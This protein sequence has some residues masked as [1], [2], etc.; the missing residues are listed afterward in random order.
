MLQQEMLFLHTDGTSLEANERHEIITAP[1][2]TRT[3]YAAM[4]I[5]KHA[6]Q[7]GVLGTVAAIWYCYLSGTTA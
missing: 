2:F 4:G 1:L 5:N 6:S 7:Y 3:A